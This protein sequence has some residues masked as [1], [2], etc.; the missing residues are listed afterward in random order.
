MHGLY[1]EP[2]PRVLKG[3]LPPPTFHS[4]TGAVAFEILL[5]VPKHL[6]RGSMMDFN[7]IEQ[8]DRMLNEMKSYTNLD[9]MGWT[10]VK[11]SSVSL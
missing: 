7:D 2:P 8:R 5:V 3:T 4:A 11:T 10:H 9:E 1:S 6:F